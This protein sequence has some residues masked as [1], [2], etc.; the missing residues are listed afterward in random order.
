MKKYEFL[1]WWFIVPILFVVS[2]STFNNSKRSLDELQKITGKP[3]SFQICNV[4]TYVLLKG[5]RTP[6]TKKKLC[7]SLD[8]YSKAFTVY[9]TFCN[10]ENLRNEIRNYDSLTIYFNNM[11]N[12]GIY[13][14]AIQIQNG[15]SIL[16]SISNWKRREFTSSILMLLVGIL[17][18]FIGFRKFLKFQ[19]ERKLEIDSDKIY[20]YYNS[21]N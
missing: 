7:I 4:T 16:Y 14:E 11:N 10:Y 9:N 8:N 20:R 13:V 5:L 1:I 12:D 17:F 21:D 19:K 2:I 6:I 18:G 15:N 3:I